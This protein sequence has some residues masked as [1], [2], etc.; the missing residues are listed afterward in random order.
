[1]NFLK[2]MTATTLAIGMLLTSGIAFAAE[3]ST[4]KKVDPTRNYES[5]GI[6]IFA[7]AFNYESWFSHLIYST[8][9]LAVTSSDNIV[10]NG[11]QEATNPSYPTTRVNYRFVK[12]DGNT[13]PS[14][15][16]VLTGGVTFAGAGYINGEV[17]DVT[18]GGNA[19]LR[20]WNYE[21]ING[22]NNN[23]TIYADGSVSI[24]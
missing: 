2:K 17:F 8:G 21:N 9:T 20:L 11:Y 5:G 18:T 24:Q 7:T 22:S 13:N 1:M 23:Y 6:S 10:L 19:K 4:S 14:D 15:D 3:D 16:V 12:S